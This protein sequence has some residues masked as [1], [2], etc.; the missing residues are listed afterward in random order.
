MNAF[1]GGRKGNGTKACPKCRL[2]G[3]SVRELLLKAELATA[4]RID[5]DRDQVLD[6]D[7][8]PARVDI[9]AVDDHGNPSLVLEFDGVWWHEG[10]EDKDAAKAGRRGQGPSARSG[11]RTAGHGSVS[12]PGSRA[13]PAD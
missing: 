8:R 4:L 6:S 13:A 10:K 12:R 1:T 3:T 9:V 11:L 7:N 2:V 5:P